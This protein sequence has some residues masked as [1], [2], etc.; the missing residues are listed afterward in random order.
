MVGVALGI[1]PENASAVGA[2]DQVAIEVFAGGDG[3]AGGGGIRPIVFAT[4]AVPFLDAHIGEAPVAAVFAREEEVEAA[5]FVRGA[6]PGDG[7]AGG[8][9]GGERT[10]GG[11]APIG[12]DPE[13][14]GFVEG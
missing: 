13:E 3:H 6:L 1:E 7:Q 5:N 12:A 9:R 2:D 14:A 4:R 10:E 11:E 8:S